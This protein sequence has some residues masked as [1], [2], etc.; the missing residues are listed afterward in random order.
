VVDFVDSDSPGEKYTAYV[1]E[2]SIHKFALDEGLRLIDANP[3]TS[4]VNIR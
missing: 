2:L 3:L 4:R 1:V